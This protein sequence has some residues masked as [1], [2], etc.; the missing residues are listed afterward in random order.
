VAEMNKEM[1]IAITNDHNTKME[2]PS[3]I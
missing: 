2:V 1:G 3:W